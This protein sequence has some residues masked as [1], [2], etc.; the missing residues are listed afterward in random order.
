MTNCKRIAAI[1]LALSMLLL[2]MAGCGT[3][4]AAKSDQN[5]STVSE[6]ENAAG[7]SARFQRG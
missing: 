1:L 6:P 4:T 2:C 5:K 7:Y 3:D